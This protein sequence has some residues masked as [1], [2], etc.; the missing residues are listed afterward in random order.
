VQMISIG[1]ESGSL[2][3][4]LA[5]VADFYEDEVDAAVASLTSAIE[6]VLIVSLGVLVGFIVISLFLPLV[7]IIN[8]LSGG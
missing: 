3:P 4:M 2:D 6:P 7:A 5:K 1:E 8:N